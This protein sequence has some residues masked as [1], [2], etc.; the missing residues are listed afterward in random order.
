MSGFLLELIRES[1]GLTQVRL[2]EQL[3]LDVATIQGWESSRRPL[4]ALQTGDLVRLRSQLRRC[5]AEPTALGILDDAIEADL[6]I[7]ETVAAGE[8]LIN[9]GEHPVGAT[10]HQR[11]LNHLITWPFLGLIP[12]QLRHL[13]GPVLP[14]RGPVPEQPTLHR[15][16]RTR[17]FDHLLVTADANPQEDAALL[18]RQAIYLLGFDPRSSTAD[19]LHTEQRRALRHAG[20]TDHVPSWV[21][22]RSSALALANSGDSDPLR[23]FVQHALVTDQQERANLNYWAYWVGEIDTVQVD[24]EFMGRIDPTGWSGVR[25]LRHL[26]GRLHPGDAH[27]ELNIHTVW[28]LLL[29]HPSLLTHHPDLR[30][31]TA[32]TID[33]LAADGELSVRARRELSDIGYAARLARR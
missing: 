2:A 7:A 17:F 31:E 26:L 28:A 3:G 22:V 12:A 13:P 23:A 20:H 1:V 33:Q 6:I 8:R 18:R 19:W 14:R 30:S 9:R 21:A 27:A 10:V 25:L 15:H 16:E 4:T 11:S 29:A 32:R 24:D 5:G